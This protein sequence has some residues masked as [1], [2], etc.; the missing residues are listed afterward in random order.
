MQLAFGLVKARGVGLGQGLHALAQG[1]ALAERLFHAGPLGVEHLLTFAEN[2][3]TGG[4][5]TLPEGVLLTPLARHRHSP[6]GLQALARLGGGLLV[7]A[8]SQRLGILDQL[9]TLAK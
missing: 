8:G 6:L 2:R 7:V 4:P 1:L 9:I 3:V 5:E